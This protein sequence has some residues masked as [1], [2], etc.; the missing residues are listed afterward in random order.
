MRTATGT[1]RRT[2]A[3]IAAIFALTAMAGAGPH[4]PAAHAAQVPH[5]MVFQKG[6][7]GYACFRIPAIVRTNAGTLLAF[8]EARRP[9]CDDDAEIHVVMKRSEDGGNEW[10]DFKALASAAG[11]HFHNPSPVVERDSGRIVLMTAQN[12]RSAWLQHGTE[13]GRR[14]TDPTEITAQVKRPQWSGYAMGPS[15]GVQLTHG[16]RPG[17]MV[18]G[19]HYEVK[20][21]DPGGVDLLGGALLYSDDKGFTW[22]IGATAQQP[23]TTLGVQELSVFQRPDGALQAMARNITPIDIGGRVPTVATALSSDA[24][25]TFDGP[26]QPVRE[27]WTPNDPWGGLGVQASTLVIREARTG[28]RYNR[29]LFAAPSEETS[30]HTLRV[31]SSYDG[32]ATWQPTADNPVLH[33]GVAGYSDLVEVTDDTYGVLFET[34]ASR[35][36]E[37]IAFA[38][39]TETDIGHPDGVLGPTTRD[40]SGAGHHTY[41]RGGPVPVAGRFGE[42]LSLDGADDHLQA[43][44]SETLAAG[45]DDFTAMLWFRYG[46]A[47]GAQALLW[48]Y[49]LNATPQFWLRAE[50]GDNRLRG[51]I[52]TPTGTASVTS[53]T[54]LDD[55]TW[56]HAV[57]RRAS[58]NLSLWIDG[59]QVDSRPAPEGSVST[60]RPFRMYVGQRLDGL[61][62]LRG[63]VDEVRMY[64]RALSPEEIAAIHADNSTGPDGAV[65]HLRMS[66]P[67]L[68]AH[69]RLE[70]TSGASLADS[71]GARFPATL[72]GG[73]A[74]LGAPGRTGRALR[75]NHDPAAPAD[76]AAETTAPVVD[77][78]R[79]FTVSA[80]ANLE[81]TA[82]NHTVVS[83]DG[84]R[85]SG[86][87]LKYEAR[88]GRWQF[89]RP[90]SDS[91]EPGGATAE[92]AQTVTPGTWTHLV[93]VYD[94]AA[95]KMRIYVNG[96]A[97]TE[98]TVTTPWNATGNLAIGRCLWTGAESDFFP[99][100]IDEVK[101]FDRALTPAEVTALYTG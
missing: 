64:R 27:P 18:I 10:K 46:G 30:R 23:E 50:P 94:A 21:T 83:Q 66:I 85:K 84:T 97:G 39:F 31:G 6:E 37:S 47:P 65:L 43:P 86:F 91:D 55:N 51:W 61:Q 60:V 71:A 74:T 13:D 57:L 44:F 5:Q 98:A 29:V 53:P 12:Y 77:T 72:R 8:A 25:E 42:G 36:N 67:G 16:D 69:H 26:F 63:H 101:L 62:R 32:G 24:A 28:D 19:A 58:G 78:T 68:K 49:G 41:L 3:T 7:Q 2:A 56:H 14:W 81:T 34:G 73:N 89:T 75:L 52:S 4:A 54:S 82:R 100:T 76:T 38:R 93:G 45:D 9:A 48:A 95:Q 80:W 90:H 15:H 70:E 87:L 22:R 79:S 33:A 96:T 88:T 17:R 99:G 1:V 59:T 92:S 40:H 20:A 11:R 35:P